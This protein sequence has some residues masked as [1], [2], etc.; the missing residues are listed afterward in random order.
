MIFMQKTGCSILIPPR[1]QPDTVV[2]IFLLKTCGKEKFPGI[3][4]AVVAVRPTLPPGDTFDKLITQNIVALDLGGGALD[5][6]GKDHCTTE[7]VAQY[8]GVDK[9]PSLAR[10]IAYARRDDREGKG[11]LSTDAIDRAFGLSGLIASL[12]KLHTGNPDLVVSSVLPLLEA[13]YVSARQHHVELPQEVA[14]KKKEGNYEE[15][16]VSQKGKKL[17]M[18][19]VVSDKPSMPTYLCSQQG[20]HADIVVQKME[21]TNHVCILSRQERKI[22]LS[23]IAALIRMREAELSG[24][25][26]PEE[27]AYLEQTGRIKEIANWY[28][29]PATNS[30]LNGGAHNRDVAES[31][32]PWEELKN[33]VHVGLQIGGK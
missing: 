4:H 12:N 10:L 23:K 29:D 28:F 33:I 31:R 17:L 21:A 5:H 13:H 6:H 20:P 27:E 26:L 3:E 9:D 7:L 11:T 1:P 15:R 22:D 24:A 25:T 30:I 19:C 2:A 8:L 14:Q 18:V 16:P 32:I